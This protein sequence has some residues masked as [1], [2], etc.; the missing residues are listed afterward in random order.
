MSK[1]NENPRDFSRSGLGIGSL[2]RHIED[3]VIPSLAAL[4]RIEKAEETMRV[5]RRCHC[6]DLYDGAMFT[7]GGGDICDD[8]F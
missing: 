8:C 5:C 2:G 3:P 1:S 7:T 4:K 6:S